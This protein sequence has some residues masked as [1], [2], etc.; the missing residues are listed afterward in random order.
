MNFYVNFINLLA[1]LGVGAS[2]NPCSET[3]GGPEAFSDPESRALRDFYVERKEDIKV[4]LAF[5][6]YGQYILSPWGYTYEHVHNYD[7]LMQIG[8]IVILSYSVYNILSASKMIL[9]SI[10]SSRR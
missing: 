2:D 4:Y 5:H 10:V 9:C 7:Q 3:F 8:K 6:S 1:S